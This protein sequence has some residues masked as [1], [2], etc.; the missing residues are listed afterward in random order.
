MLEF[1]PCLFR[2]PPPLSHPPGPAL[3]SSSRKGKN[4]QFPIEPRVHDVAERCKNI[5]FFQISSFL[6]VLFLLPFSLVVYLSSC[7][8][9][10]QFLTKVLVYYFFLVFHRIGEY[11]S[12][13]LFC[14]GT[15]AKQNPPSNISSVPVLLF[16][17]P[18][19]LQ[20][21]WR[22]KPDA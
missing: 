2:N 18:D 21:M 15:H 10:R 12:L 13:H 5:C 11:I 7:T 3:C 20:F 1:Y 4:S 19:H 9:R 22:L 8:R 16:L 6:F 14:Y 17:F